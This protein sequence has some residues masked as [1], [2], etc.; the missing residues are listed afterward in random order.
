MTAER[1]FD[2][3]GDETSASDEALADE[4]AEECF[5]GEDNARTTAGLISS[6]VSSW[7]R[8]RHNTAPADW[9]A[10][11]F[12]KYPSLWK[13]EEEMVATAHEVVANVERRNADQASLHA[14]VDAGKSKARALECL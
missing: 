4:T 8:H 9:L 11:E 10:N 1:R 2:E 6:F 12:R 3:A 7:E 13:G 5:G 14:H